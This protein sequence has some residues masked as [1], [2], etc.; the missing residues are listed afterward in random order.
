MIV[1]HEHMW[2]YE[3]S[4]AVRRF[5]DR[6]WVAPRSDALI[7]VSREGMRQMIDVEGVDA[8]HVTY[9][10]NGAPSLEGGNGK[11]FRA[12]LGIDPD[13]PLVGT[14]A[15]LSPEK[16]L[17]LLIEAAGILARAMAGAPRRDRRKR[18]R[19]G[20]ARRA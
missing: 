20:G 16:A 6:A 17:D 10:P 18:P 11:A 2:S 12:A 8:R 7:A 3:D 14:L 13:A 4:G 1:G 15:R 9:I 19:T 5:V